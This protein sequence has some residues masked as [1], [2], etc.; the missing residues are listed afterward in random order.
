MLR[1]ENAPHLNFLKKQVEKFEKTKEMQ[2]ELA[3]L[4]REYLKKESVYL[5]KE[6]EHLSV[7]RRDI[8]HEL[9][10]IGSKIS[11][12]EDVNSARGNKKVDELRI[13]EGNLNSI[14]G[15]KSE[16]E[17][18]LGRI[19]GMI[20]AK[21]NRVK[22]AGR[23]PTCGKELGDISKEQIENGQHNEKDLLEL[24]NS[25]ASLDQLKSFVDS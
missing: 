2:V 8:S 22:I 6:K 7:E 24:K 16:M 21:Q 18:K 15:I 1:R 3:T 9:K 23:C 20:E 25:Q 5:E 14:R 13:I 11:D 19:E 10:E 12:T 4:Y 17:R